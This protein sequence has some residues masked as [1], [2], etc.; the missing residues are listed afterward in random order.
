MMGVAAEIRFAH[1][2]IDRAISRPPEHRPPHQPATTPGCHSLRRYATPRAN[3]QAYSE[4]LSLQPRRR[5]FGRRLQF[6]ADGR[7][8][9]GPR[10][11]MTA[12]R[13]GELTR[14]L[15]LCRPATCRRC[16]FRDSA[17]G[18]RFKRCCD[19]L[20]VS[21]SPALYFHVA[22]DDA[23]SRHLFSA[24]DLIQA[25]CPVAAGY[26][27]S[28]AGCFMSYHIARAHARQ[29]QFSPRLARFGSRRYA[30][31]RTTLILDAI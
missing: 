4:A 30:E 24:A 27:A 17:G 5:L 11:M 22:C 31:T 3:W 26:F 14:Y 1:E 18:W 8:L 9:A 10:Q 29:R 12:W 2:N 20:R 21:S 25:L 16:C 28:Y 7:L 23:S 15:S 6:E 13:H 19:W